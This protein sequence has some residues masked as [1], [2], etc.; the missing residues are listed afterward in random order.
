MTVTGTADGVTVS[1]G[2][3]AGTVIG[4]GGEDQ[5]DGGNGSDRIDG[6]AGHDILIGGRGNDQLDGGD[7]NDLLIGGQGADT[8]LGGAGYDGFAFGRSGGA[9]TVLDFNPDEDRI[10]LY[11]GISLAGLFATDVNDDGIAD[12][13]LSFTNGGGSVTLLGVDASAPL[14]IFSA[15]E[16]MADNFAA[17]HYA[18]VDGHLLPTLVDSLVV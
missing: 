8:L 4:T 9:D 10:E 17:A 15:S 12:L 6:G 5:L 11:D 16:P 14:S 18:L 3:G 7:G 1:A 2:N 13:V